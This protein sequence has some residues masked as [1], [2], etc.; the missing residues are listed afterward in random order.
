MVQE[1]DKY[2][3]K[4]EGDVDWHPLWDQVCVGKC[5]VCGVTGQLRTP[6]PNAACREEGGHYAEGNELL[7]ARNDIL[8]RARRYDAVM[9][10]VFKEC[11][12]ANERLRREMVLQVLHPS[13]THPQQDEAIAQAKSDDNT[14]I[15]KEQ[16]IQQVSG[17]WIN[18]E[19]AMARRERS[20][21]C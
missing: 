12:A 11:H 17:Q 19:M 15:A 7:E 20:T 1:V 21:Y 2:I 5:N 3:A 8:G 16:S 4:V 10:R 14:N 18:L 13:P 9:E 6:C